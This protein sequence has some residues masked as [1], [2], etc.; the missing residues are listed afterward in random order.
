M[1]ENRTGEELSSVQVYRLLATAAGELNRLA[2]Q[3]YDGRIDKAAALEQAGK[4][5]MDMG[6]KI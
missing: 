2:A 3:L 6:E 4:T 5:I 1:D